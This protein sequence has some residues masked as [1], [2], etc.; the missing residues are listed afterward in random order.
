MARFAVLSEI[1]SNRR[2]F[3]APFEAKM[4]EKA[5]GICAEGITSGLK[6]AFKA[7]PS[8]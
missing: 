1:Y 2:S 6:A 5:H 7:A 8:D 3:H 4:A